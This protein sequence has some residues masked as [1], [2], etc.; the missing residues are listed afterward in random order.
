MRKDNSKAERVFEL[1]KVI[2]VEGF[3]AYLQVC[4]EECF[5]GIP[6]YNMEIDLG[7]RRILKLR[8]LEVF[9]MLVG[10]GEI[11]R[12]RLEPPKTNLRAL[13]IAQGYKPELKA[14]YRKYQG[15]WKHAIGWECLNCSITGIFT[16]HGYAI[17]RKIWADCWVH[18]VEVGIVTSGWL[19]IDGHN[20]IEV[21]A[22]LVSSDVFDHFSYRIIKALEE[23]VDITGVQLLQCL[24]DAGLENVRPHIR[25]IEK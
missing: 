16:E 21:R 8:C 22:D 25:F 20:I 2:K 13:L 10:A 15:A 9:L 7:I 5:F 24:K 18:M 4:G 19:R 3:K 12:I 23:P 17:Q 1:D 6:T 14:D 11:K